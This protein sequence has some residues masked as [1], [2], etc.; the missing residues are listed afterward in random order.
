MYAGSD[1]VHIPTI[2]LVEEP[3]RFYHVLSKYR[4]G[5][6]FTPNFFLVAATKY[7]LA[8]QEVVSLDFQWLL[9]IMFAGEANRTSTIEAADQILTRFGARPNTIKSAYG[10]SEVSIIIHHQ[11]VFAC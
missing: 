8:C 9:V 6:T 5:Y 1:Q 7:F 11:H 4:V 2:E 3:S 10:L